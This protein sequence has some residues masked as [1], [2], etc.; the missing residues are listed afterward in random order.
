MTDQE[1]STRQTILLA[2]IDCIEKHGLDQVTTRMISECAGTN[3]ASINYHFR[4]KDQLIEEALKTTVT[5]MLEDAVLAIEDR[6]LPFR[7]VLRNI[8]YY[9]IAGGAEWPGITTAHLY[10]IV[11]AKAYDS[12]SATMI[13]QV[14]DRLHERATEELDDQD[15]EQ[16]RLALADV[17][18]T[19]MFGMLAP[20]FFR[21][22]DRYQPKDEER[23]RR[24]ADHYTE[25]FYALL[26]PTDTP[27]PHQPATGTD[28]A[29]P[30]TVGP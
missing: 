1:I 10:S 26:P 9:L 22:A 25:L 6:S 17:F 5:H 13:K 11:V 23:F 19:V 28:G 30:C 3:V 21:L 16:L 4:T 18:S 20:D 14:F 2:A 12:I 15:P 29:T 27:S 7:Q 8:L 24:L